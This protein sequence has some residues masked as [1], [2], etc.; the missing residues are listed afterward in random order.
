MADGPTT[1]A[2]GIG[3]LRFA[4]KALGARRAR[5]AG[6]LDAYR[7]L[8]LDAIRRAFAN[9][10]DA[11]AAAALVDCAP[12]GQTKGGYFSCIAVSTDGTRRFV[13][14]IP[15]RSREMRFWDA[16]AK[17]GIRTRGRHYELLPPERCLSGAQLAVLVFPALDPNPGLGRRRTS[18]YAGNLETVVRAIAD[19]NSDHAGDGLPDLRVSQEGKAH[20]VP[21]KR[22]IVGTLG[23]NGQEARRI[24]QNLRAIEWR[25]AALRRRIYRAPLCLSHMDF[26]PGNILIGPRPPVILD[27]GHAAVAPIGTDLHTVLR[28]A[29]KGDAPVDWSRLVDIYAEVFESKGIAVDRAAIAN[30]AELHFAARYRNL[31]LQSAR[32]VFRDAL[33]RSQRLLSGPG[34]TTGR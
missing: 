10:G 24:S 20:F 19:F 28:Y 12:V 22:R 6:D 1:G 18:R 5:A 32:D 27:F 14:C 21:L 33:T 2:A 29:R 23:V 17:D 13:K 9:D 16:W 25:W 34:V 7:A 31:R 15:K 8:A 4:L 11:D 3:A 26:G 30:A